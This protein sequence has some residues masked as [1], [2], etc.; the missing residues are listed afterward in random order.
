VK[1]YRG[2]DAS[3][4]AAGIDVAAV[5]ADFVADRFASVEARILVAA[6]PSLG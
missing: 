3:R 6:E 2:Q 1:V 4:L 5:Q